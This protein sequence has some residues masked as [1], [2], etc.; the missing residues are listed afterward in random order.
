M[1]SCHEDMQL[2]V[3]QERGRE[4]HGVGYGTSWERVMG[5]EEK[6]S[7]ESERAKRGVTWFTIYNLSLNACKKDASYKRFCTA[8]Y[9]CVGSFA[10]F[11]AI[12]TT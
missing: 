11:V 2:L 10:V 12:S 9:A 5:R 8:V 1:I 7:E 6:E 3:H 4:C